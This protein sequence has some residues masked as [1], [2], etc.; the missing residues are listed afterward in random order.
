MQ[1]HYFDYG[2]T[3]DTPL[4]DIRYLL[5][6]FAELPVQAHRGVLDG[7]LPINN[8]W[9]RESFDTFHYFVYDMMLY[10][11]ITRF[12]PEDRSLRLVLVNTVLSDVDVILHEVLLQRNLARPRCSAVSVRTIVFQTFKYI[13][14]RMFHCSWFL[15]ARCAVKVAAFGDVPDVSSHNTLVTMN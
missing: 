10:G 11:R 3:V 2:T 1:L 6:V 5:L 7:V 8:R 14:R 13:T 4:T 9:C 15:A 12:Q